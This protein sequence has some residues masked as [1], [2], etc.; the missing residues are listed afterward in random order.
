[1]RADFAIQLVECV[2]KLLEN[3]MAARRQPIHPSRLR[4]PGF[5]GAQPSPLGHARQNGIQRSRTQAV[6]MMMELL[7]HP[8]PVDAAPIGGMV[9]DVNL[10]E[11]QQ[12]FPRYR[13]AHPSG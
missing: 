1:M 9:Q 6:A 2:P 12:E 10:P 4:S 11:R 13:I 3:I 7:E 5:S 8:L